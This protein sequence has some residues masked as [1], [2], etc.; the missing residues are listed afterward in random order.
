[1]AVFTKIEER[2]L[3]QFLSQHYDLG[4]FFRM[5]GIQTGTQNSNYWFRTDKGEFVFTLFEKKLVRDDVLNIDHLSRHVTKDHF[6]TPELVKSVND[7]YIV[8]MGKKLATVTKFIHGYSISPKNITGIY[9]RRVGMALAEFHNSSEQ[10]GE[11]FKSRY[12]VCHWEKMYN[13]IVNTGYFDTHKDQQD[14]IVNELE[15]VLKNWPETVKMGMTHGDLFPDNVLF[16][17]DML[18]GIIDLH[19]ADYAPYIYD[20][21]IALLAWSFDEMN[22]FDYTRFKSFLQSYAQNWSGWKQNEYETLPFFL[23]AAAL[24]FSLSR[25]RDFALD[26]NPIGK[27]ALDPEIMISRL[28]FFKQDSHSLISQFIDETR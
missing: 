7:D 3:Q 9:C 17:D 12:N 1:M 28:R 25:L 13:E 5:A 24:R 22:E 6:K 14:L 18:T 8:M 20:L 16:I 10:F 11:T 4:Q 2:E 15:Y 19:F 27:Q 26:R 21:S 23:R